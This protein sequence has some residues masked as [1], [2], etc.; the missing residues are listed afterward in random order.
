MR[1]IYKIISDFIN[2]IFP[3]RCFGCGIKGEVFCKACQ[4]KIIPIKK[5]YCKICKLPFNDNSYCHECANHYRIFK[6]LTTVGIYDGILKKLIHLF[7]YHGKKNLAEP[8]GK[9]MAKQW[10]REKKTIDYI[11]SVPIHNNR[12]KERGYNPAQLLLNEIVKYFP[13]EINMLYNN[14]KNNEN[15]PSFTKGGLGGFSR[16]SLNIL[17]R[18]RP[19]L[20]QYELNR[21]ERELNIKGA[22]EINQGSI[23]S[24][25]NKTILL[26]D[27][28]FTSGIT[29]NE[30]AGILLSAGVKEV[31]VL[32]LARTLIFC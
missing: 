24:V 32:T 10:E 21:K 18:T 1:T 6:K 3:H 5:P 29:A 20:P 16:E 17:T 23:E 27:D 11:I 31:Y 25:K 4:Q 22:F 28:I 14:T 30:I 19:T 12:F 7:K 15:N 13:Y 26:V 2:I 9:L 8:F